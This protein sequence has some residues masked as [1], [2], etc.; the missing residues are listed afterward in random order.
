VESQDH[1][2][3]RA[4]VARHVVTSMYVCDSLQSDSLTVHAIVQNTIVI[5]EVSRSGVSCDVRDGL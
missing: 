1:H 4:E 5:F 3:A 2:V